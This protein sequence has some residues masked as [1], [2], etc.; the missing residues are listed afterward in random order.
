MSRT[1]SRTMS[2][3]VTCVFAFALAL[4]ASRAAHADDPKPSTKD[5]GKWVWL[6][7]GTSLGGGSLRMGGIHATATVEAHV[8]CFDDVG[9]GAQVGGV[10][11]GEPDGRG[12][13]GSFAAGVVSFRHAVVRRRD[14]SAWLF[15]SA[16]VGGQHLS[17]YDQSSSSP[18]SHFDVR[19]VL[20]TG[21]LGALARWK[22]LAAD[23]RLDLQTMP[24]QGTSVSLSMFVGVVL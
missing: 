20:F 10:A 2:R 7:A 18:K 13:E 14:T 22:F 12:S 17:G 23:D 1:M 15:A 8:W 11:A 19:R 5:G 21:R 16:G 24:T 9:V 3:L 6:L 4:L